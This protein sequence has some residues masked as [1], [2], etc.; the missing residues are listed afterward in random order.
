MNITKH[1]HEHYKTKSKTM[2][3]EGYVACIGA[4]RNANRFFVGKS[5]G[6]RPLTKLRHR[7]EDN[8]EIVLREIG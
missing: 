6:R 7:W 2:S 4:N 3:W 1:K 8:I 5:E